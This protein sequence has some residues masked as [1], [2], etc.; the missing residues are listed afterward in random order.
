MFRLIIVEKFAM[1]EVAKEDAGRELPVRR[2]RSPVAAE[3][4]PEDSGETYPSTVSPVAGGSETD[5]VGAD[6]VLSRCVYVENVPADMCQFL[7][8]VIESEKHGGGPVELFEPD[9]ARGGVLVRFVDQQG[10]CCLHLFP[11]NR[12]YSMIS[13]NWYSPLFYVLFFQFD[14][15]PFLLFSFFTVFFLLNTR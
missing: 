11:P 4:N 15:P 10:V 1:K 14:C 7:E 5:D 6:D 13:Y 3:N 9:P 2:K 8:V 12:E